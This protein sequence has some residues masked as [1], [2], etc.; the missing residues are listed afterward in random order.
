MNNQYQKFMDSYLT[1]LSNF[2]KPTWAIDHSEFLLLNL[3]TKLLTLS[4]Q[5]KKNNLNLL[6]HSTKECYIECIN[7]ITMNDY[8]VIQKL[9]N[10]LHTT[11]M[12]IDFFSYINEHKAILSSLIVFYSQQ[13]SVFVVSILTLALFVTPNV[14]E[15][16]YIDGINFLLYQAREDGTFGYINP[17]LSGEDIAGEGFIERFTFYSHNTLLAYNNLIG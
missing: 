3:F 1:N 4:I 17:L 9:D 2:S 13:Y 6:G 8:Y 10:L 16:Y 14:E 7:L 11:D 5:E 15:H 12:T